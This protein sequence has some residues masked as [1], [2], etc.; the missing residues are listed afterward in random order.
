MLL[1]LIV[2]FLA[3]VASH[4]GWLFWVHGP[5]GMAWQAGFIAAKPANCGHQLTEGQR[6]RFFFVSGSHQQWFTRPDGCILGGRFV[7][8]L[9]FSGV[10]SFR[11]PAF[12]LLCVQS[13]LNCFWK[14]NPSPFYF[15]LT[16]W[17]GQRWLFFDPTST[18]F[19]VLPFKSL[20]QVFLWLLKLWSNFSDLR[21]RVSTL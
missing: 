20:L 8:N 14:S 4:L 17:T 18:F 16:H 10:Y 2:F 12:L 5:S 19:A 1:L 3:S 7:C 15:S 6:K 21:W 9:L 11:G 13:D